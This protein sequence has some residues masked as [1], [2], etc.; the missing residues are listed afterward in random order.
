M[1]RHVPAGEIWSPG[2]PR[3]W[4]DTNPRGNQLSMLVFNRAWRCL[5][6]KPDPAC[7]PRIARLTGARK[8]VSVPTPRRHARSS[9]ATKRVKTVMEQ[10]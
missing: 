3:Q 8:S 4:E 9:A 5:G 6:P 1:K 10:R 2:H 7:A